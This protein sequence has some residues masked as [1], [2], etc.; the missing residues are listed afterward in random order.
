[1]PLDAS[2]LAS[3]GFHPGAP[4]YRQWSR[5]L[6]EHIHERRTSDTPAPQPAKV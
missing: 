4:V 3:D 6:A 1:L 2:L 5:T